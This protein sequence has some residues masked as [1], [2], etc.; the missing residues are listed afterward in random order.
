M[1]T[2]KPASKSSSTG[3]NNE[4]SNGDGSAPEKSGGAPQ[5]RRLGSARPQDQKKKS[6]VSVARQQPEAQL[7]GRIKVRD[8]GELGRAVE[9]LRAHQAAGEIFREAK[10]ARGEVVRHQLG[11]TTRRQPE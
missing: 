9:T 8:L 6:A 1:F 5:A 3:N 10:F 11:Y 7:D 4:P 2:F